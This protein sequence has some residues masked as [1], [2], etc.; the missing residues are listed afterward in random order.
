M[1][2]NYLVSSIERDGVAFPVDEIVDRARE[3]W[4]DA[5]HEV[6]T[7]SADNLL[8][9]DME[10][11]GE[12]GYCIRIE[13]TGESLSTDGTAEQAAA[14]AVWA[15]GLLPEKV[16][17]EIWFYDDNGHVVLTTDLTESEI[18][19]HYVDGFNSGEPP[20]AQ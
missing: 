6:Y 20:T 5:L 19:S 15:R 12:P 11:V 13:P 3:R 18:W 2:T 17:S 7:G 8:T 1:S 4:G 14:V 9:L 16:P 10:P